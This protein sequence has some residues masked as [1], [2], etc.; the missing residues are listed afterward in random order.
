MT[1]CRFIIKQMEDFL[2]ESVYQNLTHMFPEETLK[3]VR[4]TWESEIQKEAVKEEQRLKEHI[5][6]E[7]PEK[8]GNEPRGLLRQILI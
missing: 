8:Y 3:Q 5:K 2:D 7:F 6:R 1:F 4:E